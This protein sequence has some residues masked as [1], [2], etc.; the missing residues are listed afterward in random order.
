MNDVK[1]LLGK[2]PFRFVFLVYHLLL[3]YTYQYE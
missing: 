2:N 3:T 1:E